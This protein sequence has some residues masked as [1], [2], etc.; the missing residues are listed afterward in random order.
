MVNGEFI[1]NFTESILQIKANGTELE[2]DPV[3][4]TTYELIENCKQIGR[5]VF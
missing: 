2:L 5:Q 4:Q 3:M 1:S